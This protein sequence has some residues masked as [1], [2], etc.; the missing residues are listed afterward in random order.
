MDVDE[1]VQ[2]M[3]N[4]GPPSQAADSADLY[5]KGAKRDREELGL[6][7]TVFE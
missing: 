2:D 4:P 1:K 6:I 7:G 3:A 5:A